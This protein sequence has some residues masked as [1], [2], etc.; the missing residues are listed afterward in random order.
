MMSQCIFYQINTLQND[1]TMR[2][3]YQINT[4]Q[5]DVTMRF[6]NQ[7]NTVQNEIYLLLFL[8][9]KNLTLVVISIIKLELN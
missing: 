5:N 2:I 3:F 9:E 4:V 7:I 8:D 1:V 6:F